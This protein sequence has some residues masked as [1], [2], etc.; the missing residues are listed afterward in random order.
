MTEP[1]AEPT[2]EDRKAG[3]AGVFD[4]AA[5][6]YDQI[7]VDF[8]AVIGERLVATAG[9]QPGERV[10]D[11]GSGRGASA[12]PAARAVGPAGAVL[13][14]DLAPGMVA[15]LRS[16]GGELP[17]LTAEVRDA[18][19]PPDGP[20]DLVLGSLVLFFLPGLDDAVRR[21]RDVLSG[22][23]RL[24]FSWFGDA[25]KSWTEVYDA[26]DADL[27][28]DQRAPRGTPRQGPFAGPE[29]MAGFL[30]ANGLGDHRTETHRITIEFTD[31]DQ[32]WRWMWSQ[33]MRYVLEMLES[34]DLLA[35]AQA[36]VDPILEQR[37]QR[38]GVIRWWTDVHYTV[39]R[40]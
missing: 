35:A 2:A 31:S 21:Y 26:I 28:A 12:L 11:L 9:P 40:P 38:D 36:R 27:P 18:E 4:R 37:L 32:Y 22:S 6:T 14:T 24:A 23:G 25:D 19:D 3:I 16:R 33:G 7:G 5:A 13:A 15:S 29:A 30:E 10:L 34:R 20:W 8:F 17:W 39:A 1:T